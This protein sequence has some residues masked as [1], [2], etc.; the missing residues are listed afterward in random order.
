MDRPGEYYTKSNKPDRKT[1]IPYDFTHMWN[2][3]NRINKQT[4]EKQ[5]HRH[6]E[7]T[8]SCQR[9]VVLGGWVKR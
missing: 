4:E 3:M 2:L 1:Q 5:T 7:E 6:R 8:D 9:G